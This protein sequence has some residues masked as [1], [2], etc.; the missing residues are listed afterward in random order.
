MSIRNSYIPKKLDNRLKLSK[1]KSWFTVYDLIWLFVAG[2][3]AIIVGI[4]LSIAG[5][6][7]QVLTGLI[8]FAL[9]F[10]LILPTKVGRELRVYQVIYKSF[11]FNSEIK[12]F[13]FNTVNDTRNLVAF[14]SI[15]GDENESPKFVATKTASKNKSFLATAVKVS[16]F[17][18]FRFSQE[19]QDLLMGNLQKLFLRIEL[20]VS[21]VKINRPL[22]LKSNK[23]FFE[24]KIIEVNENLK[25]NK[26]EK[27]SRIKQLKSYI[28]LHDSEDSFIS[29]N[30]TD[31]EFYFVLYS[32]NKQK[33]Y[34]EVAQLKHE[35]STV[36][37]KSEHIEAFELVNVYLSLINPYQKKYSKEY[38]MEHKDKLDDILSFNNLKQSGKYLS[39]FSESQNEEEKFKYYINVT[40][41]KEYPAYPTR[42]WLA[43]LVFSPSNFVMNI[44]EIKN[45]G[46]SQKISQQIQVLRAN[47]QTH[48]N[49][50]LIGKAKLEKESE[51]L[52]QLV[53]DL[54][55]G[56]E[57]IKRVNTYI[58]SY[59]TNLKQ[60][61]DYKQIFF[62]QLKNNK[63]LIDDMSFL[64]LTAFSGALLKPTDEYG[65]KYGV[66]IPAT[67][68]AE[69]FPF[70]SSNL[71]DE[72][73]TPIGL[74]ELGE[75]VLLDIF[76][77]DDNRMNHNGF[78]VANSGGGK[79]TALKV[80]MTGE[81]AKGNKIRAIDPE[82]EYA[83]IAHYFG[84]LVI[85]AGTGREGRIN[86]LQP[87]IQ[88]IDN[89]KD[90][91]SRKEILQYHIEF[92]ETWLKTLF[93]DRKNINEM[94]PMISF[95]LGELYQTPKYVKTKKITEK[96]VEWYPTFNNLID[97][98]KS[99]I[100]SK[101][102]KFQA[103]IYDDCV[104]LLE[105]NFQETGKYAELY[106]GPSVITPKATKDII[107]YN[108]QSLL[109]K[110]PN[111]IQAQLMLITS[112]IQNE[113]KLNNLMTDKKMF[114]L[115]D[116]AHLLLDEKNM[117]ALDFIYQLVKRIRKRA[118]SV[119]LATQ[120]LEDFYSTPEIA[121]KTKAILNNSIYVFIGKTLPQNIETVETM[122]RSIG[123]LT[124]SQRDFLLGAKRGEF[125]LRVGSY[126]THNIKFN[127]SQE[128]ENVIQA[129]VEFN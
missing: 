31:R 100:K 17:D 110:A 28:N 96:K 36:G 63:I 83:S 37:F 46:I 106:N 43:P 47:T 48:S 129:K 119:F 53:E 101:N 40:N 8:V 35:C 32:T 23:K 77:K 105:Q 94:A 54:S 109:E 87:Q 13:K 55:S 68:L 98:I 60:L 49:K 118:G 66:H 99:Q 1:N 21:L 114:V 12:K 22:E 122:Y 97:F 7:V 15:V 5:I 93:S 78:F 112:I 95:A 65:N 117:M 72:T 27:K 92:F 64:Q 18:L 58:Y 62:K 26:H 3:I 25:W 113:V 57:K 11:K 79:T 89:D 33:L 61:N 107:V 50:D 85:D 44:N 111:L 84:G 59:D 104:T 90:T 86:P 29:S 14:D 24:N 2:V 71:R 128:L 34:K 39:V 56:N 69:S 103:E 10:I 80:L 67:A 75:P 124:E 70:L 73:G 88:L 126:E 41:I 120:N 4:T 19:E 74:N 125:I 91:L 102:P 38:I 6:P 115:I 121:K 116:E 20:N 81:L 123:G 127:I 45:E 52:W 108:I 9:G 76:I 42:S 51:I 30:N 82:N 16:G